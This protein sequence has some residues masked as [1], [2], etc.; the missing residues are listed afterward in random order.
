MSELDK[1]KEEELRAKVIE[2]LSII[3]EHWD[4]EISRNLMMSPFNYDSAFEFCLEG[5]ELWIKAL[6]ILEKL[7]KGG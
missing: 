1:E 7:R 5:L 3:D 4:E 2:Y 6:K